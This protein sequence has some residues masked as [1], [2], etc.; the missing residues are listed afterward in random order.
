MKHSVRAA[1]FCL[2]AALVSVTAQTGKSP[3]EEKLPSS[4][5]IAVAGD[6]VITLGDL[7]S[8]INQAMPQFRSRFATA[9]GRRML[10][11]SMID[12]RLLYQEAI[13]QRLDQD[14][15]I[16]ERLQ[17]FAEQLYS[18]ELSKRLLQGVAVSDQETRG[19]YDAHPEE[20]TTPEQVRARHIL[21]KT[22]EEAAAVLKQLQKGGRFDELAKT[23]SADSR[24]APNGGELG[25][26]RRGVMDPEFDKAAFGLEIGKLSGVVATGLGFHI[27]EVEEKRAAQVNPFEL[28]KIRIIGQLKGAKQNQVYAEFKQKLRADARVVI[29]DELLQPQAQTQPDATSRG[30]QP[31]PLKP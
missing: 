3:Q 8:R 4:T 28:E 19:Y 16:R 25:W 30:I 11:N 26:L 18:A 24:T 23:R 14:P 13:R 1:L 20:F 27:I 5:P 2:G 7:E 21:L 6:W 17:S 15:G 22:A 10:L 29:R 9:E 12:N 31:A